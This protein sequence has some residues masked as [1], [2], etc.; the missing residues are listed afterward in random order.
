M[1]LLGRK[2]CFHIKNDVNTNVILTSICCETVKKTTE[3]WHISWFGSLMITLTLKNKTFW[4]RTVMVV[5]SVNVLF[6]KGVWTLI[7]K[8]ALLQ[9]CCYFYDRESRSWHLT[10]PKAILHSIIL[11]FFATKVS[12][13]D[14]QTW[15]L[16]VSSELLKN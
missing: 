9:S 1:P 11:S 5:F 3:I 12:P 14:C 2:V 7:T 6:W 4:I 13:W 10:V 8:F 15:S 16:F